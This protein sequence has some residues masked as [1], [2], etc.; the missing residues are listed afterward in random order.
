MPIISCRWFTY[1]AFKENYR[2]VTLVKDGSAIIY[3]FQ[4]IDKKAKSHL[5]TGNTSKKQLQSKI[6]LLCSLQL[7]NEVFPDKE[8][9]DYNMRTAEF[10]Q[11]NSISN[12]I[13]LIWPDKITY[14]MS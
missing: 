4:F 3:E 1:K 11:L 9:F 10:L 8:L 5:Y 2:F 12:S 7:F 13:G 6:N 14:H